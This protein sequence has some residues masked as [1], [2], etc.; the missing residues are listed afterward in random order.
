MNMNQMNAPKSKAYPMPPMNEE[1]GKPEVNVPGE[2]ALPGANKSEPQ[3]MKDSIKTLAT[4]VKGLNNPEIT[5]AFKA[6][7][8]ALL[9]SAQGGTAQ[10]PEEPQEKPG[11][12]PSQPEEQ[13]GEPAFNPFEAPKAKANRSVKVI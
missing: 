12:T 4:F 10:A 6:F 8:Q 2:P 3:D 7:V 13:Q 9:S 1:T 11:E 5:S